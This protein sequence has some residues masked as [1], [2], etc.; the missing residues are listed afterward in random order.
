MVPR[1]PVPPMA[2]TREPT[3]GI[4]AMMPLEKPEKLSPLSTDVIFSKA[5]TIIGA[6]VLE[7]RS[8]HCS[9]TGVSLVVTASTSGIAALKMSRRPF[10]TGVMAFSPRRLKAALTLAIAPL[11]VPPADCAAPPRFSCMAAAKFS[12][13]TLPED[14]IF[15]A[16]SAVMP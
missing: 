4:V 2:A 10:R 1:S 9:K 8:P 16:S 14:T 15:W 5:P 7:T 13:S 6:M 12:K 3:N 11:K